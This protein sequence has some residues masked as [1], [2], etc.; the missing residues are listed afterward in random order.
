MDLR[1]SPST[2]AF[3]MCGG[4]LRPKRSPTNTEYMFPTPVKLCMVCTMPQQAGQNDVPRAA[5][6]AS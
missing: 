6:Y 3:Q 5:F 4:A 2:V 1:A